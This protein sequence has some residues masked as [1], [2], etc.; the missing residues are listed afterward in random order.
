MNSRQAGALRSSTNCQRRLIDLNH[1]QE[2]LAILCLTLGLSVVAAIHQSVPSEKPSP[3]AMVSAIPG[4]VPTPTSSQSGALL[5]DRF[6]QPNGLITNEY[7]YWKPQAGSA[8]RS[9]TWNMTSGSLFVKDRA[10]WTGAPD[11]R[12]PNADS[13][14]GNN[15]AIFRLTTRSKGFGDV[16]VGF[17]LYQNGLVST[18]STPSAAWDGVHIF[19]RYQSRERLYYASV[20]RRDG[21]V[22]IKKKCGGG[23][24]NGGTYYAL[25]EKSGYPIPTGSWQNVTASVQNVPGGVALKLYRE[26]A[27]VLAVTDSGTGCTPIMSAGATGVRGDNDH[28]LFDDFTVTR[29][30]N[31]RD[32]SWTTVPCYRFG[33]TRLA[34]W[35]YC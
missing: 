4:A 12:E 21:H 11:D 8:K 25:A 22:V 13:S 31:D 6:D 28:F 23:P 24:S 3:T 7:A 2:V 18:P 16:R 10:A 19:L 29:S 35:A 27:E 30:T 14:R 20:N 5:T 26:G 32:E 15:S 9:A 1:A 33:P 34:G 17:R